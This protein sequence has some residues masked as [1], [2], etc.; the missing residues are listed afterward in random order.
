[1]W[2]WQ[3]N[4]FYTEIQFTEIAYFED[5]VSFLVL[6]LYTQVMLIKMENFLK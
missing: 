6:F 1:M 4:P 2:V 3:L 5:F